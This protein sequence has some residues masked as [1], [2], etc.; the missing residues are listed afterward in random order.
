MSL[1]LCDPVTV[2]SEGKIRKASPGEVIIGY[3][4][5]I[6][7]TYDIGTGTVRTVTVCTGNGRSSEYTLFEASESEPPKPKKLDRFEI[8][9]KKINAR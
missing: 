1:N 2:T 6:S 9:G 7:S 5:N 8:L 3:V 4:A